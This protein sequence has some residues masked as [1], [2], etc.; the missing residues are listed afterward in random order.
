MR[1]FIRPGVDT[2]REASIQN[3]HLDPVD[4]WS[5]SEI[6]DP[7]PKFLSGNARLPRLRES[8]AVPTRG[9]AQSQ[10]LDVVF[11]S[12]RD[13]LPRSW[14]WVPE[15]CRY[16]HPL[17][18]P[19]RGQN[20]PRSV[21]TSTPIV[22][23]SGRTRIFI[24]PGVGTAREA[25]IQNWHFDPVDKWSHSEISGPTPKFLSGSAVAGCRC[26]RIRTPLRSNMHNV[27]LAYQN[28]L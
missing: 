8:L 28:Y 17:R 4:K 15:H 16:S 13:L 7:A 6:S 11:N 24:R 3:R 25:P 19:F 12:T 20:F 5:H 18:I 27:S 14:I 23:P 9:A 10:R 1:I 2:A 21:C 22:V 26:D